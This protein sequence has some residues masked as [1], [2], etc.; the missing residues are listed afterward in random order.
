MRASNRV[1]FG[2]LLADVGF[3]ARDGFPICGLLVGTT[4]CLQES[5]IYPQYRNTARQRSD[6]TS[7]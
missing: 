1:C 7:A 4:R 6:R 3:D 2:Q 5:P